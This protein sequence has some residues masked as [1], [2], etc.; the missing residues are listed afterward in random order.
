MRKTSRR[1]AL[2]TIAVAMGGAVCAGLSG[3]AFASSRLAMPDGPMRLTR[4]IER[5]LHGGAS[6]VVERS[7]QVGFAQSAR[8]IEVTGEQVEA[9][10]KAPDNLAP[11][12][13][14]EQ[15]RITDGMWPIELSPEG[16]IMTAGKGVRSE[17]LSAA[18]R[19]AEAMIARLNLS[20]AEEGARLQTLA[21]FQRAGNSVLDTLP[22]D[23]FYPTLG[24]M[25]QAREVELANGMNGEFVVT[26]EATPVTPGGWLDRAERRVVTR[27][28]ASERHAHE[29]W[30]LAEIGV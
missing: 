14:I 4:R 10:V 22:A 16:R 23:L 3:G 20:A 30:A 5:S 7:W 12:A 6:L 2:G 29:L 13:A 17:D 28:G 1:R 15:S 18:M 11:L 26:Y 9:V 24:P 19:E 8:G 21:Q 27:I 25:R